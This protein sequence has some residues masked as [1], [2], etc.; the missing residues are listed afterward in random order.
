MS[1]RRT[2]SS[3]TDLDRGSSTAVAPGGSEA[4]TAEPVR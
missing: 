2:N 3:L 4:L 1:D